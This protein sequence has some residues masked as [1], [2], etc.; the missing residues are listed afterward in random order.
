MRSKL[1]C[2]IASVCFATA[3][4]GA[5]MVY[6]DAY[7][8]GWSSSQWDMTVN[9]TS[10]H[11]GSAN[12]LSSRTPAGSATKVGVK[13]AGLNVGENTQ[14]EFW[15]NSR[16]GSQTNYITIFINWDGATSTDRPF[17][18]RGYARTYLVD[19]VPVAYKT[20]RT[21]AD[22]ATWQKVR[23]DI[24]EII[25]TGWPYTVHQ[26]NPAVNTLSYIG[27]QS[28]DDKLLVDDIQLVSV[29]EP[30]SIGLVGAAGLLALRRRRA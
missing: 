17:D 9:T 20:A 13:H 14:L 11:A 3:A 7:G 22:G 16:D 29:P 30:T 12:S 27:V 4:Q 6:D 15:M 28:G 8:A 21:D 18:D 1:V 25:N 26:F 2:A 23:I 5:I 19:D 24:T 10:T